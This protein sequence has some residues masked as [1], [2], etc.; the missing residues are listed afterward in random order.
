MAG[1]V[2]SDCAAAAAARA[3]LDGPKTM[4]DAN[5]EQLDTIKL[6]ARFLQHR[7]PKAWQQI[8]MNAPNDIL[9]RGDPPLQKEYDY[10]GTKIKKMMELGLLHIKVLQN[11]K[12]HVQ[13]L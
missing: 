8:L 4:A 10:V 7:D 3:A 11:D 9:P 6:L 13:L 2:E 12:L 5:K 1:P